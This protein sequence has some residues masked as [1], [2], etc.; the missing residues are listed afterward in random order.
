VELVQLRISDLVDY[1]NAILALLRSDM[2]SNARFARGYQ[3]REGAAHRKLP[4]EGAAHE[5]FS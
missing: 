1:R 4:T 2:R 5:V 3:L